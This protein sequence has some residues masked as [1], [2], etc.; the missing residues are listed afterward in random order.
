VRSKKNPTANPYYAWR[1]A[2]TKVDAAVIAYYE[3][4]EAAALALVGEMPS[5]DDED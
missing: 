3:K 2:D 5:F 1:D 4:A